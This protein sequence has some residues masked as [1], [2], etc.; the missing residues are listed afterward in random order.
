M[1]VTGLAGAVEPE[2]VFVVRAGWRP[3]SPCVRG[4]R[5]VALEDVDAPTAVG[6]RAGVGW[7][8]VGCTVGRRTGGGGGGG[9]GAG[10]AGT[11]TALAP[12]MATPARFPSAFWTAA[13]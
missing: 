6:V 12:G 4:V 11:G 5:P 7:G 13:R 9:A 10:G 8:R 1:D 2:A 3:N